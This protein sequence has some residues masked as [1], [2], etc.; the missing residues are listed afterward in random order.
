MSF[1]SVAEVLVALQRRPLTTVQPTRSGIATPPTGR[2]LWGT[3]LVCFAL[4]PVTLSTAVP[5]AQGPVTIPRTDLQV[6]LPD[7]WRVVPSAD[8]LHTAQLRLADS[9]VELKVQYGAPRAPKA[10]PS[11]IAMFAGL[12]LAIPKT[13]FEKRPAHVP[14][15]Y[16]GTVMVATNAGSKPLRGEVACLATATHQLNVTIGYPVGSKPD[17][18]RLTP[19]MVALA[20]AAEAKERPNATTLKL[21]VLGVEIPTGDD[22]WAAHVVDTPP[23]GKRDVLVRSSMPGHP[24]M[25]I[26]FFRPGPGR[27]DA[28]VKER[29]SQW[30]KP[31]LARARQYGGPPWYADAL[32]QFA[33]PLENLEA[34]ACRDMPSGGPLFASIQYELRELSPRDAGIV[35]QVL[36]AVGEASER[37][38]SAR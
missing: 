10:T 18:S 4:A 27:C 20:R 28:L 23:S 30:G 36:N 16:F 15:P 6:V 38:V 1:P 7:G 3:A 8:G 5:F 9:P 29:K 35:R 21:D 2:S 32:E 37:K 13:Q 24:E 12:H 19:M 14:P 17:S 34:F 26:R 31:M 33:A 22:R 25:Q 11:C